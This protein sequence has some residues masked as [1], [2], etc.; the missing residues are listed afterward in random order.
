MILHLP[1]MCH[2]K[3]A[4]CSGDTGE[5][6]NS[7]PPQNICTH[8]HTALRVNLCSVSASRRYTG[9]T[10]R[11]GSGVLK[12]TLKGTFGCFDLF[13]LMYSKFGLEMFSW[14]NVIKKQQC[15]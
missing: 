14:I 13:S 12:F 1:M 2:T 9:E 8:L 11:A 10:T 3:E 4:L 15:K 6:G 5:A 7:E